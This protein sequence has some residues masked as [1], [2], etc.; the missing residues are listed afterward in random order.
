MAELP[1]LA[2]FDVLLAGSRAMAEELRA[3]LGGAPAAERI[4][5]C[6][7]TLNLG[8]F[9]ALAPEPVA[10]P[11]GPWL[12]YVGR[13]APHKRLEDL[14]DALA[15]YRRLAGDCGLVL[16]GSGGEGGYRAHV[17]A[18]VMDHGLASHVHWLE[19]PS[20]G[21]LAAA[22]AR[23]TAYVSASRHEGF[24][25][26]LVEAMGFGKPVLAHAAP[27]VRDTLGGAGVLT[28]E[29]G[30]EE[31]A[32]AWHAALSDPAEVRRV[33]AAQDARYAELLRAADG[34]ILADAFAA[35]LS[36][37]ARPC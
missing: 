1:R 22:Y 31:V 34:A 35:A 16:A 17:Q 37:A 15:C 26:P 10:L 29:L 13:F 33:L 30:P 19:R 12:L 2:G 7:P 18:R 21:Q 9:R 36:R 11:D 20:D 28:G 27:A 24:G 23:C 3:A 5:V 8:R 4:R 32:A 6:P 25:I 14:V